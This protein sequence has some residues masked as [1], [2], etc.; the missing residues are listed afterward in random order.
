MA[1]HDLDHHLVSAEPVP[2]YMGALPYAY[3]QSPARVVLNLCGVHP[4]GQSFGRVVH[5]LGLLDTQDEEHAPTRQG[6]ER[7]LAAAHLYAADT[8]TYWHCHAGLNR[9]GFAVA[10][11][12]HL[13]RGLPIGEAID[14]LRAVRSAFVLCNARFETLLREWYGTE[15]EQQFEPIGM[16]A[17]LAARTGGRSDHR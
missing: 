10:A 6:L 15:A 14:H 7:F 16:A 5:T 17:Y 12:L 8:P 11:Y 4:P 2:L 13:Y 3:H 1:A 9:S